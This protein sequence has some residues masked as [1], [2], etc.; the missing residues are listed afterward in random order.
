[1]AKPKHDEYGNK[2]VSI[3]LV[4]QPEVDEKIMVRFMRHAV[5]ESF[6]ANDMVG[7]RVD[8]RKIT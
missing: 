2:W 7:L 8:D 5:R 3:T 1:M 4:V 6:M